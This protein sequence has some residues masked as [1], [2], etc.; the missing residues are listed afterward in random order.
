MSEARIKQ[1]QLDKHISVAKAVG[2]YHYVIFHF[3][4]L[5]S[6]RSKVTTENW[7]GFPLATESSNGVNGRRIIICVKGSHHL[8]NRGL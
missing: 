4:L 7:M 3:K 5:T 8:P 1:Y 6:K 2:N